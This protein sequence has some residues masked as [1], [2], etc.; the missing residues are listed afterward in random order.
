MT[1]DIV[2]ELR[3][4]GCGCEA[5]LIPPCVACRAAD[6]IER[7]RAENARHAVSSHETLRNENVELRA[8]IAAA[9]EHLRVATH[10][11]LSSG[12]DA[13]HRVEA[14]FAALD[15]EATS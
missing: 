1:T 13:W 11:Q 6:E 2:D 14:A 4:H 8:R 10:P 7:L 3:T 15:G 9:R 12:L 5:C